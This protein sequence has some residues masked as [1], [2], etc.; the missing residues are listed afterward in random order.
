MANKEKLA[1]LL[2]EFKFN[3]SALARALQLTPQHLAKSYDRGFLSV[4]T[5]KRVEIITN[6]KYKAE[7]LCKDSH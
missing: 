1:L 2:M 4:E 5:A 6:G 7:E 3:K